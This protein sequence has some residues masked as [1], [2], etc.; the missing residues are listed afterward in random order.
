MTRLI[1]HPATLAVGFGLVAAAVATVMITSAPHGTTTP[2]PSG[3]P[4]DPYAM[5]VSEAA[6]PGTD[7]GFSFGEGVK[8]ATLRLEAP[9]FFYTACA[10]G[11]FT[12]D[13]QHVPCTGTAHRIGPYGAKGSTV[14]I[15]SPAARWALIARDARYGPASTR[16]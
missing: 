13:T 16:G 4:V 3:Q 14:T 11:E 7:E 10:T 8:T 1:R 5:A 9:T 2:P 6:G 12:I 15:T